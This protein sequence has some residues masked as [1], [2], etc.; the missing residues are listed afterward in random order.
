[1]TTAEDRPTSAAT[2]RAG[3]LDFYF[4]PMCP[5]TWM[6]SRWLVDAARRRGLTVTWRSLSLLVLSDG[7]PDDEHAEGAR[8]AARAHRMFAALADAGRDDLVGDLYT[9]IGTRHHDQAHELTVDLVR[10]AVERVGAGPWS[11]A[12]DDDGW[13]AAVERS[14]KEALQLAGPDVGSPVLAHGTPRVGFFGPI[15]NPG[16]RGE[17]AARLLDLVLQATDIEGFFELKRGRTRGPLLPAA[18]PG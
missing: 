1:M 18:P 3:D 4:D 14:T 15:V 13:D 8:V 10:S 12:I 17:Q 7:E 6:T 5:W 9:E 16:P 2:E 11:D